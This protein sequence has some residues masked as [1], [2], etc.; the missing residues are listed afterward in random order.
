M[1]HF[2]E[3]NLFIINSGQTAGEFKGTVTLTEAQE[4]SLKAGLLYINVHTDDVPTGEI[5]GQILR[6]ASNNNKLIFAS[7]YA[8]FLTLYYFCKKINLKLTWMELNKSLLSTPP[9]QKDLLQ[10]L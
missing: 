4:E 10:S 5:R 6:D 2:C 7:N 8:A 9:K 3:E 1:L